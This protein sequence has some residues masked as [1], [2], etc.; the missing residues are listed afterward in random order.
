LE[1][2]TDFY[3]RELN[4][5]SDIYDV[6]QY[7]ARV[8][9]TR[10][11]GSEFLIGTLSYT[12][13]NIGI[14]NV[15]ES[16]APQ[17]IIDEEGDRWVSKVGASIAYD[18]LDNVLDIP[19]RGQRTEFRSELAGGPFGAET[20]F[21]KLELRSSWY[22][23]PL[24]FR[25]HVIEVLG[26]AGVVENYGRSDRVHLFDRYFLGGVSTMRGFR[27][28]RVGPHVG[29]EPVGG[30]TYWYG[31]VEYSLPIIERLRFALFYDIGNVY[32][33][34]YS[35]DLAAGQRSYYDNWGVGIR[36]NIPRLGYLRLDYGFPITYDR[37]TGGSG[38]FQFSVGS[39]RVD[40]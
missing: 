22:F 9:L 38:R 32:L 20:D 11:L 27:Y 29:N 30:E 24:P 15:D 3:Y 12:I 28:R 13:E 34:A 16:R 17:V 23:S 14:N 21:Y 2:G 5:F 8:S 6:S 37:F 36:L 10:A 25:G 39:R 19:T 26:R 4:F 35:F 18:T 31:T 40:F 1:L 33:N 7:G